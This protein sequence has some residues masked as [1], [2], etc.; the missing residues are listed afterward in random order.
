MKLLGVQLS[1]EEKAKAK[2]YLSKRVDKED[3]ELLK[4]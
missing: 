2:S 4:L 3:L 1:D